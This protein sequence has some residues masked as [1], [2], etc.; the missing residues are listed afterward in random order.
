MF[1]INSLFWKLKDVLTIAVSHNHPV[2]KFDWKNSEFE[3]CCSQALVIQVLV[4]CHTIVWRIKC[5]KRMIYL[6]WKRMSNLLR[7]YIRARWLRFTFK[8]ININSAI[9]CNFSTFL[10]WIFFHIWFL[11]L[12]LRSHFNRSKLLN[13]RFSGLVASFLIVLKLTK[14]IEKKFE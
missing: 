8:W 7:V 9:K 2:S 5:E 1:C 12:F 6:H 10:Y 14:D 3:R 11:W 4:A 13:L